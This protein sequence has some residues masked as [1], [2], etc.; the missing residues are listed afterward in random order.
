MNVMVPI[1]QV[2]VL[3]D[4]FELLDDGSGVDPDSVEWEPNE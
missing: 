3:D 1:K 4:E 2:A